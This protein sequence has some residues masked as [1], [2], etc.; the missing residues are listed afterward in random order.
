MVLIDTPIWSEYLRRKQ[1]DA[2]VI[3]ELADLVKANRAI[4]IGP[5]RQEVLAGIRVAPV[6]ACVRLGLRAFV[7]LQIET[8][9]YEVA[10]EC[11]TTC[12]SRGIQGS[13][14]DFLLCAI[15]LRLKA[16]IFTLDQDFGDYAKHLPIT[17]YRI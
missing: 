2:S 13:S 12:R 6:F 15:S 16:P 1:P 11:F 4:L 5:V 7:D 3:T 17:L 8:R 14:T 10:A 9:D